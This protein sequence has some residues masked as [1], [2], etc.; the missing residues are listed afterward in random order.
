V[1][2]KTDEVRAYKLDVRDEISSGLSYFP[3][4]LFQAV[5]QVYRNFHTAVQDVF[6]AEVSKSL[7]P[8]SFLRLCPA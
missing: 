6:G 8:V 4:S 7:R 5:T 2:W 3:Q 1:L